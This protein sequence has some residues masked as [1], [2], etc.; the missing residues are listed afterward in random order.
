MNENTPC[1]CPHCRHAATLADALLYLASVV[2]S[3]QQ[4]I[5]DT[6]ELKPDTTRSAI[7]ALQL[8]QRPGLA[9]RAMMEGYTM[10]ELIELIPCTSPS[11]PDS[12]Y[13]PP[14]QPCKKET[15]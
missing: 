15:T 2:K 1:T 10:E 8:A 12:V 14:P 7:L 5:I 6:S 11:N 13:N 3:S 9:F 4:Q